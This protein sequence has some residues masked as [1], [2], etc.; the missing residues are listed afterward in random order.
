MVSKNED[1]LMINTRL[2]KITG[3]Y[4]LLDSRSPKIFGHSVFK[5]L[6]V[7]QMSILLVTMIVHILNIYYFSDDIN[8]VMQYLVFFTSNGISIFKIYCTIVNSDAIWNCI[9]IT[10]TD[11]LSYHDRR[12]LKNGQIKSKSYSILIMIK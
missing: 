8:I 3:L 6:S 9:H 10:S 1:N 12:I 7:V 5:C 11:D 2:M 4:Y